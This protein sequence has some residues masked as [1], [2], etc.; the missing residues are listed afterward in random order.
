MNVPRSTMVEKRHVVFIWSLGQLRSSH[1]SVEN[2]GNEKGGTWHRVGTTKCAH[3]SLSN[4][5]IHKWDQLRMIHVK[6]YTCTIHVK[7]RQYKHKYIL[8]SQRCSSSK[9]STCFT[10]DM[11]CRFRDFHYDGSSS[12]TYIDIYTFAVYQIKLHQLPWVSSSCFQ[13]N[14]YR[15]FQYLQGRSIFWML[16]TTGGCTPFSGCEVDH[17]QHPSAPSGGTGQYTRCSSPDAEL[18]IEPATKRERL[19]FIAI[20]ILWLIIE[21]ILGG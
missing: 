1:V 8:R 6:L 19:Y 10:C 2:S 20:F 15:S 12:K 17:I 5:D 13:F 3:L 4:S 11:R 16:K 7:I 21:E 14:T 18:L 9:R